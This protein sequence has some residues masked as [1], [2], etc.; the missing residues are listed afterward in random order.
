MKLDSPFELRQPV[1][2]SLVRGVVIQDDMDLRVLRLIGQH[3]IQEAAKILPPLKL[4]ELRL[5][6][7]GADFEGGK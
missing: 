5:D 4:R 1:V 3:A 2:V 6:V 7:A